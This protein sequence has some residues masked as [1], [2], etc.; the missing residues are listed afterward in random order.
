MIQMTK[1]LLGLV[2]V[3]VFFSG[4]LLKTAYDYVGKPVDDLEVFVRVFQDIKNPH[5][6]YTI[7]EVAAYQP[8][9]KNYHALYRS[10]RIWETHRTVREM[11]NLVN[12]VF[13]SVNG[14][15]FKMIIAEKSD[16]RY[17]DTNNLLRMYSYK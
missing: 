12:E 6:I 11:I 2:F 7:V 8:G 4:V 14:R 13:P 5:R 1:K 16:L 3:L 10:D 15:Y 17:R 9:G